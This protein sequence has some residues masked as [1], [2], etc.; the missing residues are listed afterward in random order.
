MPPYFLVLSLSAGTVIAGIADLMGLTSIHWWMPLV[1]INIALSVRYSR[2]IKNELALVDRANTHLVCYSDLIKQVVG[3]K[4]RSSLLAEIQRRLELVGDALN[5]SESVNKL[6]GQLQRRVS[7]AEL[8]HF[9]IYYIF[10]QSLLLWDFHCMRLLHVWRD[11]YGKYIKGWFDAL[12]SYEVLCTAAGIRH[13]QADWCFPDFRSHEFSFKASKIGHPLISELDRVCNDMQLG[14]DKRLILLSGSNMSGKSTLLRTIGCN[15]ILA[16]CG[17]PVCA[18]SMQCR[19]MHVLTCFNVQDSLNEGTSLFLA[20][21]MR[22]KSIVNTTEDSTAN[23]Q[24]TLYL[25]D[26]IL[27]GTNSHERRIAVTVILERLLELKTLGVIST[28]DL[29]LA[30]DARVRAYS[31]PLHFREYMEH[32]GDELVMRFDYRL[33]QGEAS[34][35]NALE[36]LKAVGISERCSL[37]AS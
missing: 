7:W 23:G 2:S 3:K 35:S 30:G 27:H 4:H 20:E 33:K 12:S 28:H 5:S 15:L 37:R 17:A 16:R 24:Q 25:L 22:M 29:E 32:S 13:D 11:R 9:G 34:S 21:L 10:A 26:E 36:L 31:I 1:V 19:P 18:Q 6:I 8:R 14:P